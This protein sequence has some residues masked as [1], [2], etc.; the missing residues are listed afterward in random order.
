VPTEAES[1][2]ST[3]VPATVRT[4]VR[5]LRALGLDS[6]DVAIV[7][8]SLSRLGWVAGGAQ[9]VVEALLEAVGASGTIV[10]PTQSGQL[11]DPARWCNPPIPADWIDVIRT[12]LPAFDPAITPT[13]EMGQIVECFRH[14]PL[15]SRSSH[16]ILSFAANGRHADHVVGDHPLTPALGEGSPLDRLYRL[17]AKVVLI[18]VDHRNDTSLHLAE[19]RASWPS[20]RNYTEG[21][22]IIV[23]GA[24]R[25]VTYED[26]D[27]DDGDF[28]DIG[29]AFARTGAERRSLVACAVGRLCRLPG[30]V[31]FA[32]EWIE[33]HRRQ[34]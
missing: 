14:H 19:H 1:I 28:V 5:D 24:R 16:P 17:D 10:M 11:S 27:L 3:A 31:D 9:A 7:H 22:P 34:P 4:L 8:S 30:L 29:E 15:T 32:V 12:E 23:G 20:K 2:A 13:R 25:W 21:V 6:G 26:L 18:G 33:C